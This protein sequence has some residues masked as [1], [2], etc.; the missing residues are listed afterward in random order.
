MI[1]QGKVGLPL[2]DTLSFVGGSASFLFY[3]TRGSYL[4]NE[5]NK[6]E[7]AIY[8]IFVLLQV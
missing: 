3:K 7:S 4:W 1:K 2:V 6:K 8:F 5:K